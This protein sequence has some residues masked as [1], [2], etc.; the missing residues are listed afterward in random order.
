MLIQA[1]EGEQYKS[2]NKT[3]KE[4]LLQRSQRILFS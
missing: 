3:S 4:L 1:Y 2:N